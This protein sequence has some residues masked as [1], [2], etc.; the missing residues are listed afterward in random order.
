ML[1]YI[2]IC[3]LVVTV[4][5]SDFHQKSDRCR[6]KSY[7]LNPQLSFKSG[8]FEKSH[9]ALGVAKI[10]LTLDQHMLC[11]DFS[12]WYNLLTRVQ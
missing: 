11:K 4:V 6:K 12:N 7:I 3:Q 8:E 2:L 1:A 5:R 9:L 10:T